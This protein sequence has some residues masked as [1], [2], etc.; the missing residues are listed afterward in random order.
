M[1]EYIVTVALTVAA[2]DED[3]A[4]SAAWAILDANI[5]Y[6]F[7]FVGGVVPAEDEAGWPEEIVLADACGFAKKDEVGLTPLGRSML[8]YLSHVE[9]VTPEAAAIIE[10]D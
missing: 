1:A 2:D 9:D 5:P 10:G 7:E 8:N 6:S 3:D 4:A